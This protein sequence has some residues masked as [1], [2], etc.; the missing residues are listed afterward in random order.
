MKNIKTKTKNIIYKNKRQKT[1]N[2]TT[3]SLNFSYA[4]NWRIKN[5]NFLL[6]YDIFAPVG[7]RGAQP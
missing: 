5:S 1:K 2:K 3:F 7:C 4:R 6:K